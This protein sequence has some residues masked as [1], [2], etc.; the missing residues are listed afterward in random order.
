MM[1]T[2]DFAHSNI[3]EIRLLLNITEISHKPKGKI[4]IRRQV[5]LNFLSVVIYILARDCEYIKRL[6]SACVRCYLLCTQE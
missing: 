3:C 2:L 1:V 5:S 4:T 6:R